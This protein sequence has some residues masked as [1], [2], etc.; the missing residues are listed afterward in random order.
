MKIRSSVNLGPTGNLRAG[1]A[2]PLFIGGLSVSQ[3]DWELRS[4]EKV[5]I[6]AEGRIFVI[7]LRTR[8]LGLKT[9]KEHGLYKRKCLRGTYVQTQGLSHGHQVGQMKIKF[10]QE[11]TYTSGNS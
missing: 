10:N 4:L 6:Y 11:L 5:I 9:R 8:I 3:S 2:G 1:K 7:N